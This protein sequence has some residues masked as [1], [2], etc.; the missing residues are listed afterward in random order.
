MFEQSEWL[1]GI[2]NVRLV[3]NSV[4]YAAASSRHII[5]HVVSLWQIYWY[6]TC[7][8]NKEK[9]MEEILVQDRH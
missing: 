1:C 6:G 4:C 3:Y 5:S 2:F 7:K 8:R 9:K